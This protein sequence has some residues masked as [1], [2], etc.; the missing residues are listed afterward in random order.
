MNG[1]I[2]AGSEATAYAGAEILRAGGNAVDAAV[3][4]CFAVGAGEPTLTSLGGAGALL[5]RSGET[6]QMQL[7]DFF[8]DAPGLDGAA[9][10][11]MD[12]FGVDLDFGPAIQRFHIGA[13]SAAVP[14]AIPGLC[15][16]LERWGR[17]PLAEVI[18]PACRMLREGQPL[19]PFQAGAMALLGPI[20]L[21][22]ETGQRVFAPTG[23]LMQAGERFRL[24]ELARTLERLARQGWQQHYESQI[25]QAMLR[26]YGPQ[27]GGMLGARDLEAYEV[28][29]REPLT[30][31]YGDHQIHTNPPPAQGGR[32]IATM[33]ALLQTE[34]M[35]ALEPGSPERNHALC[36]AMLV[37]DEVRIA[38]QELTE[39]WCRRFAALAGTPLGRAPA[40]DGGPPSTT[41]VSVIDAGG[42]AAAVTFSYGEGNGSF[43]GETGIMMNNLMGEEDLFPEGFHSWEPGTRLSTMVS[44]SVMVSPGGDVTVLGS[45]GANRIRTAMT[46]VI[47]LLVDRGLPLSRAVGTARVHYEAGVLNAES[48]EMEQDAR[49]EL[50][51]LGAPEL[52]DFPEPNLFFGGV[53]AVCLRTD[54]TL[55]AAGDPRRGGVGLVVQN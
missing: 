50:A 44:P 8:A 43:I 35:S 22:S 33:L 5:Y 26:Q 23:R 11:E 42:D 51:A 52:I 15:S 19:G 45:G 18:K 7:C 46:Q 20:L 4:A 10:Q 1:A 16:S 9:P 30:L 3:G 40:V 38:G 49:H 29:L 6:G 32:M 27:G 36:R 55:E 53:H 31:R 13:A 48:F 24:P 17:L 37:A 2:A 12:F 39:D 54:G 28:Q 25:C 47:S 34:Q 21:Q 14:G 41:H